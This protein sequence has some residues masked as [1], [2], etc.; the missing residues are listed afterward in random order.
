MSTQGIGFR[1]SL[2]NLPLRS[3]YG[4]YAG[5]YVCLLLMQQTQRVFPSANATAPRRTG[6]SQRFGHILGM[7]TGL[8]LFH[9]PDPNGFQGL[10]VQFPP[11]VVAHGDIQ[12]QTVTKVQLLTF[13]LVTVVRRSMRYQQAVRAPARG[14]IMD[15]GAEIWL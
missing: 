4:L 8:D 3:E 14:R 12:P 7:S 13:L 15:I 9:R 11:I 6:H 2:P 5:K 1:P 10:V